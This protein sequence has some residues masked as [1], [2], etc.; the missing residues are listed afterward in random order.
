MEVDPRAG[1][2][3]GLVDPWVGLGVGFDAGERC[4]VHLARSTFMV[5]PGVAGVHRSPVVGC[6]FENPRG[7]ALDC[8]RVF[9]V[10]VHQ[11]LI[12]LS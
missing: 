7:D 3:L 12:G 6:V 2:G 1:I 8:L 4:C 9:L 10:G 5:G 11:W